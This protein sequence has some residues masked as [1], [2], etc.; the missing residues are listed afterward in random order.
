MDP[1]MKI[2]SSRSR[3]HLWCQ[4]IDDSRSY[5]I[6]PVFTP[7]RSTADPREY[8]E[9]CSSLSVYI[10]QYFQTSVRTGSKNV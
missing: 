9:I 4:W 2:D 10:L 6:T 7:L 5:R 8:F 1:N 3:G